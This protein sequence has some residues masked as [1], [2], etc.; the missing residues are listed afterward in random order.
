MK[1]RDTI[2]IFVGSIFLVCTFRASN[3]KVILFIISILFF[4]LAISLNYLSENES[5]KKQKLVLEDFKMKLLKH[6]IIIE[7]D[8]EKCEIISNNEN[9]CRILFIYIHKNSEMITYSSP[10]IY[11]NKETLEF[12]LL[13]KK[14][15]NIYIDE[16]NFYNFYFDIEFL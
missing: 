13:N 11:K 3:Y 12:L 7:V 15:T 1:I 4:L 8:F 6:C 16:T 14:N 2:L 9:E 5:L 10:I